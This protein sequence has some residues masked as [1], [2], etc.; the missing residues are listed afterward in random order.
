MKFESRVA[1]DE[2]VVPPP[3]P[4]RS[5]TSVTTDAVPR[6]KL[7]VTPIFKVVNR[8]VRFPPLLL[9]TPMVLVSG[10]ST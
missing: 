8:G 10:T 2:S 9:H 7:K 3:R 5:T 4:A 6:M 1:R